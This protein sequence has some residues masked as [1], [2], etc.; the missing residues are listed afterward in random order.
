MNRQHFVRGAAGDGPPSTY[1]NTPYPLPM[2]PR[3]LASPDHVWRGR[4][5]EHDFWGYDRHPDHP[6]LWDRVKG[7]FHGHGPKNYVRSDE[8]IRE[9]IC[10]RL[11]YHPY[12]DATDIEVIVRDGE[13]TLAGTVDGRVVKRAAEDC[14]EHIRGVKDVHNHLRVRRPDESVAR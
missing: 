2:P 3:A 6:S 10:E 11:A 9:D 12:V 7:V 4:D 1:G 8:R 13:V 14:V 5:E